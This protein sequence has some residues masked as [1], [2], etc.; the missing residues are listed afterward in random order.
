MLA[1]DVLSSKIWRMS[2]TRM[3]RVVSTTYSRLPCQTIP[4]AWIPPCGR[5]NDLVRRLCPAPSMYGYTSSTWRYLFVA[6]SRKLTRT[7]LAGAVRSSYQLTSSASRP[8]VP[9][10]ALVVTPCGIHSGSPT[11]PESAG[12]KQYQRLP[13]GMS[14]K[15]VLL[16]SPFGVAGRLALV[17]SVSTS[18]RGS[19]VPSSATRP[20][21]SVAPGRRS[22]SLSLGAWA[23]AGAA[24]ASAS[25]AAATAGL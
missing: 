25:T 12:S 13:A 10:S 2:N 11:V 7:P 9:A 8:P 21:R 18:L 3:P 15:A 19:F 20:G 23:C 5:S 24:A 17:K 16:H 14:V 6:A 4:P 22:K 1:S